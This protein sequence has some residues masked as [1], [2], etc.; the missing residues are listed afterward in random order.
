MKIAI[1]GASGEFGQLAARSLLE[2]IP[3]A[4][5]VL[6]SRSPEKLAAFVDRGVEFRRGD[7]DEPDSLATAFAGVE[8][9]LLISTV[10]VG[11]QRRAQQRCA[12]EAAEAAGVRHIAYTSS[13]GM[14]PR[15]PSFIIPDH[16]FTEGLLRQ[17]GMDATIL[18]MAAYADILA[19]AIAPQAI[20]TG[21]WMSH[22][23]DGLVGFVAKEDCARAAAHAIAK[24]GHAGAIYEITGPDLLSYRDAAAL[25]SEL[26]GRPIA[27]VEP[28]A[29]DAGKE[30]AD[31]WIGPFTMADLLSTERAIREGFSAIC[32]RH[33]EM[34]TGRPALSLREVYRAAGIGP[35]D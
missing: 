20:A 25:A 32:S 34:I 21:Q 30:Q 24:D 19:R 22:S 31:T 7:F 4:D 17:C 35:R 1:S 28:D 6:V 10:A 26:S 23:G 13:V 9:L 11:E 33:V 5:I 16:A 14:H 12:I 27:Y 3:A 18:R 8:R 2:I 15:N 29:D